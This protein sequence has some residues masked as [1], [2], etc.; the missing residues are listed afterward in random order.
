MSLLEVVSL[1]NLSDG[2][3]NYAKLILKDAHRRLFLPAHL[4]A[5][6]TKV[7]HK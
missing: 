2:L 6:S 5:E 4:L 1:S 7:L 3:E